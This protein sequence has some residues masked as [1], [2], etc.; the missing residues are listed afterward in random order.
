MTDEKGAGADNTPSNPGS[1]RVTRVE[2]SELGIGVTAA[3]V[4]RV[5]RNDGIG[6]TVAP[7]ATATPSGVRTPEAKARPLTEPAPRPT[8]PGS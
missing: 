3:P 2:R 5:V 6:V 8:K 1:G 7:A 4:A